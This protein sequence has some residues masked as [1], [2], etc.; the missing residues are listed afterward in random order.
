MNFIFL[1]ILSMMWEINCS[2]PQI[3]ITWRTKTTNPKLN[4]SIYQFHENETVTMDCVLYCTACPVETKYTLHFYLHENEDK[5]ER[6]IVK[7]GTPAIISKTFTLHEN[8]TEIICEKV[9]HFSIETAT[10]D[11]TVTVQVIRKENVN[12]E[13]SHFQ[14]L[15]IIVCI[16]VVA[17]ILAAV[18]AYIVFKYKG[19]VGGC[20]PT[21]TMKN[22]PLPTPPSN[23][24]KM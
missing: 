13:P 16:L 4:G 18:F 8:D 11:S 15:A 17:L 21:D 10:I 2:G 23:E 7:N 14:Y 24:Y 12:N 22:R 19:K 6:V 9:G 3:D 5:M 1:L 20:K